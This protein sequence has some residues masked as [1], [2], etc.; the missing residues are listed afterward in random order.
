MGIFTGKE[1]SWD[2]GFGYWGAAAHGATLSANKIM[3]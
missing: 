1:H 3:I 2:E